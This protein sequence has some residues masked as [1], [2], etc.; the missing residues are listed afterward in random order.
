LEWLQ[1]DGRVIEA[2]GQFGVAV[3]TA[4][5]VAWE[6]LAAGDS[7]GVGDTT[8]EGATTLEYALY[9]AAKCAISDDWRTDGV[10]VHLVQIEHGAK[11]PADASGC[12]FS[13]GAVAGGVGSFFTEQAKCPCIGQ[14][15][16]AA[17]LLTG[18]ALQVCAKQNRVASLIF[19]RVVEPLDIFCVSAKNHKHARV[20]FA[21]AT[22]AFS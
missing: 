13:S 16:E 14:R 20:K 8:Q 1:V 6:V 21:Q 22:Q 15:R 18:A 19:E 2:H 12:S 11:N 9:F 7:A 3:L 5:A 17:K 10:G 4:V